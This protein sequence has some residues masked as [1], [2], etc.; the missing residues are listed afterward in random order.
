MPKIFVSWSGAASH[1]VAE[2]LKNWLPVIIQ[3]ATVFISSEDLKK[4][5][6]WQSDLAKELETANF[7]IICVTPDNI[8]APWL[9]FEAGAVSKSVSEG[10]VAPLLFNVSHSGISGPLTQFNATLFTKDDVWKLIKAINEADSAEQISEDILT[11]SFDSNWPY[12]EK[13]VNKA[14]KLLSAAKSAQP[15][16]SQRDVLEEILGLLRS[17]M[18]FLNSPERLFP[19][20]YIKTVLG[21]PNRRLP[22]GMLRTIVEL[23]DYF[24]RLVIDM[25][26]ILQ[27][28]HKRRFFL[29]LGSMQGP[30]TRIFDSIGANGPELDFNYLRTI[31]K[32]LSESPRKPDEL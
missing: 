25:D 29:H 5:V 32:Y 11:R 20:E 23:N 22:S 4:G 15:A 9:L 6:R 2:A 14:D 10:R 30:V 31:G 1:C 26:E 18:Q 17:Q 19:P 12:L 27:G 16:P 7:G 13:E 21:S 3:K 24:N 28:E 8:S